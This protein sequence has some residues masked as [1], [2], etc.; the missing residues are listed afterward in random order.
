MALRKRVLS[1]VLCLFALSAGL[2]GRNVFV[3]PG[4]G[5]QN[6]NVVNSETF[7]SAVPVAGLPEAFSV[8]AKPDGTRYYVLTRSVNEGLVILDQNFTIV[9]RKNL[10]DAARAAAITPDGRR[11]LVLSTFLKIFDTATD[12]EIPAS[13]DVGVAPVDIAVSH[14]STRAFVIS[15]GAG[16]VIA[17]DL[18]SNSVGPSVL[19]TGTFTGVAV[20]PNGLVYASTTNQIV[21]LDGRTMTPVGDPI[22]VNGQPGKLAFTPDGTK[23]IAVN[24]QIVTGASAFVIDLGARTVTGVPNVG[25]TFDSMITVGYNRAFAHAAQAQTLYDISLSPAT[26]TAASF[27][28]FGGGSSVAGVAAS[29]ELPSAKSLFVSAGSVIYR[30]DLTTNAESGRVVLGAAGGLTSFAGPAATGTPQSVIPYNNNQSL[31]PGGTMQPFIVRALDALGRPLAGVPVT[32]TSPDGFSFVNIM[33]LTNSQGIAQ[34]MVIP[35]STYG[36]YKVTATLGGGVTQAFQFTVGQ[37]TVVTPGAGGIQ[38]LSGNGQLIPESSLSSEPLVVVVKNPDG[39][40]VVGAQVTFVV[41][42]GSMGLSTATGYLCS[43]GVCTTDSN[44]QAGV[45]FTTPSL[46]SGMSFQPGL[47]TATLSGGGSVNFYA[48]TYQ[49]YLPSGTPAVEPQFVVLKPGPGE[50]IV[51]R[52]GESLPGAIQVRVVAGGLLQI[53]QPIPNVGLKAFTPFTDP[54]EGPVVSCPSTALSDVTGLATCDLKFGG[55]LGTTDLTITV[56]GVRN[57]RAIV[58]VEPGSPGLIRLVQGDKQSGRGGQRLP[59][60]LVAEVSDSAGNVLANT[61]VD[62][63]LVIPN[64]ATLSNVGRLTDSSGRVRA[65]VTL[66]QTPGTVQIRVKAGTAVGTYVLTVNVTIS[67]MD[68]VSGDG[69]LV[70]VNTLFPLPLVVSISDDQGKPVQGVPVSFAVVSGSASVATPLA[71][72]DS[73]GR[74]STFV[75]AGPGAG[76]I[77][78]TA[79]SAGYSLSFNLSSRLA[80]PLLTAADFR[81][82]ASGSPGVTPG[83]IAAIRGAGIAPGIQGT[84]SANTSIG[85]LPLQLQG[86]EVKFGGV[87]APIFSISNLGGGFEQIVVQVPFD[88]P[89]GT[90][91]VVIRSSGGGSSTV[92]GVQVAAL[93]PGIFEAVVSGARIAVAVRPDGSFITPDN[94]ARLGEVVRFYATG[95]GQVTPATG[96]N[97]AGVP[98]QS[99]VAPVVAGVNN[100]GAR[101]VSATYLE[102]AIGVY[103]IAVEI[104]RDTQTGPAQPLGLVMEGPGGARVDANSVNIPI[105]P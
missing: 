48:T 76:P 94:P 69:Q 27:L 42:Q 100:A 58:R 89:A 15:Q 73:Q 96:T 28:G 40:P 90:T 17:I 5:A 25:F 104:P 7:G 21:V 97:R 8:L 87:S 53:G 36:T 32:F 85:V 54:A 9:A 24:R 92:E 44:G 66:G 80:G 105:A 3:M 64:S 34:A 75:Q 45:N 99:V 83:G 95:L 98:G 37:S 82:A 61:A 68:K 23:G 47:I 14:D 50:T 55:K 79:S 60:D 91:A 67:R 1:A 81:N 31:L 38:M 41:A 11:L 16:R 30:I 72:T 70:Q 18:A 39:T 74:A 6:V 2:Q 46:L 71:A 33:A 78:V 51:G 35:P 22:G 43:S 63:E 10:G 56:G 4:A 93:Q 102:G 65:T 88:V 59:L 52:A 62:W 57:F 26:A 101:L 84:V 49:V 29:G 20:G 13:I 12:Q 19:L 86:V 103:V 77:V